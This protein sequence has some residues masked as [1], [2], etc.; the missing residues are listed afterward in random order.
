MIIVRIA[1]RRGLRRRHVQIVRGG[2]RLAKEFEVLRRP[3]G[4]ARAEKPAARTYRGLRSLRRLARCGLVD[5]NL[6]LSSRRLGGFCFGARRR[7][8][9]RRFALTVAPGI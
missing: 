4:S 7:R 6:W 1:R 3:F 9:A 2:D 8:I 5:A